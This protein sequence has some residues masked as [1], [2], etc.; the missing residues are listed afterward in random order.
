MHRATVARWLVAVRGRIYANVK[1]ELGLARA[2][3]SSEL[4]SLVG[5]LR[6]EI[7]IKSVPTAYMLLARGHGQAGAAELGV[8]PAPAE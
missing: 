8:T 3:S 2:P 7:H 6:D 4:R 1:N 5:L